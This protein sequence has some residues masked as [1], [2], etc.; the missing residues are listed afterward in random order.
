MVK[1]KGKIS[2]NVV[3]FSEYMNFNSD[4]YSSIL[5]DK[6]NLLVYFLTLNGTVIHAVVVPD[7]FVDLHSLR[8]WK[9][10]QSCFY[11]ANQKLFELSQC[12]HNHIRTSAYKILFGS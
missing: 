5:H 11:C 10:F 8:D 9:P 1:S 12:R 6:V 4:I 2:Q 7:L 3:A